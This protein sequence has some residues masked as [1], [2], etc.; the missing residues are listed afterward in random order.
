MYFNE[1]S[2]VVLTDERLECAVAQCMLPLAV[3][4]ESNGGEFVVF[5]Y[6]KIKAAQD[7]AIE[8]M[9]DVVIQLLGFDLCITLYGTFE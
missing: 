1:Y 2:S 3:L 4:K 6:Y 5:E 8:R 9:C 7:T